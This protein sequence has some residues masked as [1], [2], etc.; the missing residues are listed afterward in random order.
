MSD[1]TKLRLALLAFGVPI[2]VIGDLIG[3]VV[4]NLVFG[5]P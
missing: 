2:M 3:Q 5:P 4:G 1:W